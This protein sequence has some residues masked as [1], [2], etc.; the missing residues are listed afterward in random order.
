MNQRLINVSIR[1]KA[2]KPWPIDFDLA[3]VEADLALRF[4]QRCPC[5]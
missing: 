2:A 4:P 5:R 1:V 3:A